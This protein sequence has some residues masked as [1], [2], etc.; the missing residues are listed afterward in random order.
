MAVTLPVWLSISMWTSTVSGGSAGADGRVGGFLLQFADVLLGGVGDHAL[1]HVADHGQGHADGG[2]DLGVL[3]DGVLQAHLLGA[4]GHQGGRAAA[5]AH[6][7]HG[8]VVQLV[9]LGQGVDAG[10]DLLKV[11]VQDLGGQFLH[12]DAQLVGHRLH[13]L[14]GRAGVAVG[15]V[16]GLDQAQHV[17][18][19]GVGEADALAAGQTDGHVVGGVARFG[20]EHLDGQRAG[21][22]LLLGGEA[23]VLTAGD[24]GRTGAHVLHAVVVDTDHGAAGAAQDAHIQGVD[25]GVVAADLGV[26][27]ARDGRS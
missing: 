21:V 4:V 23:G 5:A 18:G 1:H 24:V 6:Q 15:E 11:L 2:D 9:L 10:V 14:A 8:V 17:G 16:L 27:H 25:V 12:R 7:L 22:D 19:V 3:G 20:A 13:A 26:V